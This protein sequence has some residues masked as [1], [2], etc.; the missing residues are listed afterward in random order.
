M[1]LEQGE[2]NS[3]WGMRRGGQGGRIDVNEEMKGGSC[4]G[5]R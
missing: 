5:E 1:S 2:K 3:Q 4:E